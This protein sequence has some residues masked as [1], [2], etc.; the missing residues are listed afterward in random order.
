MDF[1]QKLIV[2]NW[3]SGNKLDSKRRDN[4]GSQLYDTKL[5]IGSRAN[6]KGT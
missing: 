4:A 5:S 1:V 2:F 3:F 6:E